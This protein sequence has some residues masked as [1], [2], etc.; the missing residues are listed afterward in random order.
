VRLVLDTNVVVSALVWGG[1]PFKLIEAAAAGSIEIVA[2]PALLAELR[3][4]LARGHLSSRL[5]QHQSTVEQ[6]VALYA[7]LVISV[8]PLITPRVVPDDADDDHV[9]AAAVAGG[10][11]HIVSGDQHLL[12][13]GSHQGVLMVTVADALMRI[14]AG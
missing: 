10:A 14:E 6:A 5:A 13:M 3:E 4:V 1:L 9:V 11:Q 2:S 12:S 8:S 7:E